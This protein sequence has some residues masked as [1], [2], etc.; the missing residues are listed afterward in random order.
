MKL[1][2]TFLLLTTIACSPIKEKSK[3]VSLLHEDAPFVSFSLKDK[4]EDV[5]GKLQ[6]A[7]KFNNTSSS[8]YK[9]N[10]IYDKDSLG[11]YVVDF[12]PKYIGYY[13]PEL[14]TFFITKKNKSV[15][16]LNIS[17]EG[18]VNASYEIYKNNS[19][20]SVLFLNWEKGTNLEA[21][22]F[23][24]N[25]IKKGYFKA[26]D[27][28]SLNKY[29][30][31]YNSLNKERKLKIQKENPFLFSVK[32]LIIREVALPPFGTFPESLI[33]DVNED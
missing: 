26:L 3:N 22:K 9:I 4:N 31:K 18:F 6:A 25:E 7:I 19:D 30:N 8:L 29:E 24:I 33:E 16:N 20:K 27:F 1:I 13:R 15:V 11:L 2:I 17:D 32:Q 28:I 21:I 14:L 12:R 23:R 10:Y 5:L